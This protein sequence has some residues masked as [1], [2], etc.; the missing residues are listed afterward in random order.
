MIAVQR[1]LVL[2]L[3]AA[4]IGLA[5]ARPPP[6]PDSSTQRHQF[7]FLIGN[8]LV[9]DSSG[10]AIGTTSV[11]NEYGGCVL[12]E[13]WRGVGHAREGLGVIGYQAESGSWHRDFIDD[14]GFVLAFDGRR[15]G[16]AMVMTGKEYRPDSVQMH[17]VTWT[18]KDGGSVEERWQ[19]S[20]DDGR[21]WRTHFNGVLER[22]AE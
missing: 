20:T 15:E 8:W 13:R 22:I 21:S 11:S 7:D 3:G 18:P 9:R 14:G 6:D 19:I 2:A 1:I 12:V 10:R 5:A 4:A 16:A 17:R